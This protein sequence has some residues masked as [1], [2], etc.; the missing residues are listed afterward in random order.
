MRFSSLSS[1][2]NW[3]ETL[4]PKTIE[5]GLERVTKVAKA[6]MILPVSIPAIVVAGTNGKGSC[7]A[8][9]ET[10]LIAE[11]YQVG[12]Y[13]SPHLYHY[14][15]RIRINGIAVSDALICEAFE[16]INNARGDISLT[17]FEF[18]TLAALWIFKLKNP[19]VLILE[20]GMG[21]RLDAVNIVDADVAI[22]S[23]IDL[24]HTEWLGDTREKIGYEKAGILRSNKPA[25]CGDTN[26][27]HSIKKFA[28]QCNATLFCLNQD[29]FY[30]Q[31][32]DSNTWTW[33]NQSQ[34]FENLPI[35]QLPLQ[36]AATALQAI[37]I[38]QLPVSFKSIQYGLKNAWLPGRFQKISLTNNISLILDVTH[39]PQSAIFLAQKL[40]EE[41]HNKRTIAIVGM[42]K[43]KD[44][45]NTLKPLITIIDMW[46]V[47]P[48]ANARSC[49]AEELV[50][51][52]H[53]LG[54]KTIASYNHLAEAYVEV[55]REAEEGDR[56]VIFG[57]FYTV[58]GIEI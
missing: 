40:R 36:N 33:W 20:V 1:W 39:N 8:F 35:T 28:Q 45:I 49:K 3:L 57:S 44:I 9:C 58:A 55:K 4:H 30:Q 56:I 31:N 14:N 16:A 24:D 6:L 51:I 46:Y 23:T 19:D 48:L 22:I 42:L 13:I 10:I 2:L 26:P 5:L 34:R 25:V 21:G 7:V 38:F 27:P 53:N 52:L 17:Y 37:N 50:N 32:P 41:T 12:S 29:F 43:D 15:E 18:G 54:A 11:G 47:A